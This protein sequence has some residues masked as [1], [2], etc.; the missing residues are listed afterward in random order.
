M[1]SLL[2]YFTGL[3]LIAAACLEL[4]GD[5]LVRQGL[6]TSNWLLLLLGSLTLAAYGFVVNLVPWQFSKLF[7]VYVAVFAVISVLW[8][9]F[10]FK[11]SIP[12]STWIGIALIGV[13]GWVIQAGQK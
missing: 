12:L 4:G 9:K 10:L 11:E 5:A 13:G 3:V 1:P 8:G 6:G 2:P 7:G